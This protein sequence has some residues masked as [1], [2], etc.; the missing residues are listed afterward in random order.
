M[1]RF[2]ELELNRDESEALAMDI[3]SICSICG[4]HRARLRWSE[5]G[6]FPR[7]AGDGLCAHAIL[8]LNTLDSRALS[9]YLKGRQ[10]RV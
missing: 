5:E 3:Y 1:A 9:H 8:E 4:P 10:G 2:I 7:V 6:S